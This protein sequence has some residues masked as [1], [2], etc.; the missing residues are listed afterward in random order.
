MKSK[1]HKL[2]TD[3]SRERYKDHR[4]QEC[5]HTCTYTDEANTTSAYKA[6][7][8]VAKAS[9]PGRAVLKTRLNVHPG[10]QSKV[11]HQHYGTINS[12]ISMRMIFRIVIG[13]FLGLEEA[14]NGAE[15]RLMLFGFEA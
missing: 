3:G 10:I 14:W 15:L 5:E 13:P 8:H 12:M 4:I 1:R 2:N 11:H 6:K 9:S 7:G